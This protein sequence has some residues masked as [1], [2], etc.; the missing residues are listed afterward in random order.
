MSL[1]AGGGKISLIVIRPLLNCC[2]PRAILVVL[3]LSGCRPAA[4]PTSRPATPERIIT[5]APNATEII[6]SLGQTR[7]LVG[8]SDFCIW[9]PEVRSLPRIGGLFDPKLEEILR[10]RPDLVILRGRNQSVEQL[11]ADNGIQV[12][13]DRTESFADIYRTL[14]DLGK[15]LACEP[16]AADV[17]RDMKHRLDAIAK[18][19]SGKPRPRVFMTLARNPDSLSSIMTG[20]RGTFI[21]EMINLAGG[22]N[23][24][25]NLAMAYPTVSTESI[26][27]A[28][29][30][31]IIDAMP[32]EKMTPEKESRIREDWKSLGPTPAARDGR[33]HILSDE[34]C[35]IPSPRIVEVIAKL[36]RLV[37]PEA[38][39]D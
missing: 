15:L 30:D 33:I 2:S 20:T 37:H 5:L 1:L 3:A 22:E 25:A 16:A 28:R 31:V 14:H 34:N 32:E 10:L 38:Q 24:F 23:V 27:L 35:Y 19:V 12:M 8:V 13:L 21:D 9:P 18:A 11:C 7:R 36:A 6:G 29:P 4:P 26:L 39:I 17:E